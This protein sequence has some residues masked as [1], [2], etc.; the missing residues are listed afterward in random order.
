MTR[1]KLVIVSTGET[2]VDAFTSAL[3]PQLAQSWDVAVVRCNTSR[4]EF[5][6]AAI[7]HRDAQV[8]LLPISA[9]AF[10]LETWRTILINATAS[11]DTFGDI[12][13]VTVLAGITKDQ[14]LAHARSAGIDRQLERN[15]L[16]LNSKDVEK[17]AQTLSWFLHDG[18]RARNPVV[19]RW[20]PRRARNILFS[21]ASMLVYRYGWMF[22]LACAA[23]ALLSLSSAFS[24]L[25]PSS[26]LRSIAIAQAFLV[27]YFL[28]SV[29]G[30]PPYPSLQTFCAVAQR[31]SYIARWGG[32]FVA[33]LLLQGY[34]PLSPI[35]GLA[36]LLGLVVSLYYQS[37]LLDGFL[38]SRR[39]A[40]MGT[41]THLLTRWSTAVRAPRDGDGPL[42]RREVW[43][44]LIASGPC[45][46][47]ARTLCRSKPRVFISY[48][49]DPDSTVATHWAEQLRANGHDVFLDTLNIPHEFSWRSA[50]V[51]GLF[52]STHLLF[53]ASQ[54]SI[55][56]DA[57]SQEISCAL[58]MASVSWRPTVSICLLQSEADLVECCRK[59]KTSQ[60]DDLVYPLGAT[61]DWFYW[62]LRHAVRVDRS[63]ADNPDELERWLQRS[64]P[65]R[66]ISD[67]KSLFADWRSSPVYKAH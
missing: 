50:I 31:R 37:I 17:I 62:L 13:L 36:I 53:F 11:A 4:P 3:R 19:R 45:P 6:K 39:Q 40:E 8:L 67:L 18:P 58:T 66:A 25:L 32:P 9:R 57:C 65:N 35:L 20:S 27:G 44:R 55:C 7:S 48:A 41:D 30:A 46:E 47:K 14:A 10:Q 54:A 24:H 5:D 56:S 52:E 43:N 64:S 22:S 34:Q 49:R 21:L 33:L 15:L 29:P 60:D 28:A 12:R 38:F 2:L 26:F 16:E 63:L 42:T 23:L 59:R 61:H 51:S 1:R